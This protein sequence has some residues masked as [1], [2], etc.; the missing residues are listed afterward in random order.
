M[1]KFEELRVKTPKREVLV[2]I[3]GE[4]NSIVRISAI[5]EGVCRIFVPHTTAG[6]T[7]NENA[8]PAVM[9]DIINFLKI[10]IPQSGGQYSFRH[11]EGNSDAH[12]KSS[13][14]GSSLDILIHNGRLVLGTWQGIMFAEYDGPRNR[15][16]YIQLQGE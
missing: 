12:I 8:D 13:L 15:R 9:N 6:V 5:N 4:V 10:L 3:T 1:I 2:N 11:M 14:T 16:V 7:I